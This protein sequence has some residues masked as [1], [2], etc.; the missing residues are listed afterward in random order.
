MQKTTNIIPLLTLA[1]VLIFLPGCSA[2][3]DIKSMFGND[4]TPIE[5]GPEAMAME[6]MDEFNH[7]QYNVALKKFGE[8]QERFPFSRFSLM[9]ELKSADCHFYLQ[10]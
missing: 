10:Q 5:Q 9:A 3:N 4:T 2:L 1:A 6:A 7:A 8:I